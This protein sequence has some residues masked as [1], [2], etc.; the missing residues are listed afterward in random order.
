[1]SQNLPISVS[2]CKGLLSSSGSYTGLAAEILVLHLLLIDVSS[3]W[4]ALANTGASK[5]CE[6]T[7]ES[8][9]TEFDT[10]RRCYVHYEE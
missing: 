9:N 3:K 6:F 10:A 2:T 7:T 4:L 8:W 5:V 1:M